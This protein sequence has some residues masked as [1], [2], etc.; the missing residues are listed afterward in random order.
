MIVGDSVGMVV[1]VG[2]IGDGI[3]TARVIIPVGNAR[4]NCR[5]IHGPAGMAKSDAAK[6]EEINGL[7]RAAINMCCCPLAPGS[8]QPLLLEWYKKK[9]YKGT[10]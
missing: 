6:V 1:G 8:D 2:I 5:Q 10:N 7:R 4:V 3:T 9:K